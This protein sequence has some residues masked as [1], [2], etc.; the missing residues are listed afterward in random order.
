[1]VKMNVVIDDMNLSNDLKHE[2]MEIKDD[3]HNLLTDIR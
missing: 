3:V 2:V 1:M